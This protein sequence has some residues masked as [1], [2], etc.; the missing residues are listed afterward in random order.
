MPFICWPL[1]TL[2]INQHYIELSYIYTRETLKILILRTFMP[3][4]SHVMLVSCISLGY[5]RMGRLKRMTVESNSNIFL[6]C[7]IILSCPSSALRF[8]VVS[9]IKVWIMAFYY[10]YR[11]SLHAGLFLFKLDS[12]FTLLVM[13]TLNFPHSVFPF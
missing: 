8:S 2:N 13:H 5:R 11:L 10:Y 4:A 7:G 9:A 1:L 12:V 6:L 3:H